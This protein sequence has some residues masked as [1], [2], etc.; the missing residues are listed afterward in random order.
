MSSYTIKYFWEFIFQFSL[1]FQFKKKTPHD[2]KLI[3]YRL[4]KSTKMIKVSCVLFFVVSS[5]FAGIRDP[6]QRVWVAKRHFEEAIAEDGFPTL[7]EFYAQSGLILQTSGRDYYLLQYIYNDDTGIGGAHVE[8]IEFQLEKNHGD[9]EHVKIGSSCWVKE[10]KAR[11]YPGNM[12]PIEARSKME[13]GVKNFSW[14]KYTKGGKY[15]I[16]RAAEWRLRRLM[17]IE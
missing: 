17:G 10:T 6:I 4:K 1:N 14:A 3:T 15:E 8:K 13:D 5:V 12:T 9:H 2:K 7:E 16:T 11:T